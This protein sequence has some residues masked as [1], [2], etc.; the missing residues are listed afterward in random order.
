MSTDNL[1]VALKARC[2]ARSRAL[3]DEIAQI[4]LR[5]HGLWH[6]RAARAAACPH[7]G[8]EDDRAE[9]DTATED[10]DD[11]DWLAANHALAPV[12]LDHDAI[13][14]IVDLIACDVVRAI[15]RSSLIPEDLL[16]LGVVACVGTS[17]RTAVEARRGALCKHHFG[18]QGPGALYRRLAAAEISVPR[19]L[20]HTPMV[21]TPL[22]QTPPVARRLCETLFIWQSPTKSS[23]H[24]RPRDRRFIVDL[25]SRASDGSVGGP[26]ARHLPQLHGV[27]QWLREALP[28]DQIVKTNIHLDG[29]DGRERDLQDLGPAYADAFGR[30]V[31]TL[32]SKEDGKCVPLQKLQGRTLQRTADAQ[33]AAREGRRMGIQ[34]RARREERGE[35]GSPDRGEGG[36]SSRRVY[37]FGVSFPLVP[38]ADDASVDHPR[39]HVGFDL[40][41]DEG[42]RELSLN[43]YENSAAEGTRSLEEQEKLLARL[44]WE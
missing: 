19:P 23:A 35:Y 16:A 36:D 20:E 25:G 17:W 5:L 2:L 6:E 38:V 43:Y 7:N 39:L 34:S 40:D 42:F 29:E 44:P 18:V 8:A 11:D 1:D 26:A 15:C 14:I 30:I 33:A 37:S 12:S 32:V 24:A 21:A 3:E 28:E 9:D 13:A 31:C 22:E 10:D 4:E 27:H 41:P